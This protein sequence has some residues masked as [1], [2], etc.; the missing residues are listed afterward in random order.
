MREVH[1]SLGWGD[2]NVLRLRDRTMDKGR[3]RMEVRGSS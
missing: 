2:G 3:L 1:S